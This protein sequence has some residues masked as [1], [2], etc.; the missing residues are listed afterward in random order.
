MS[1]SFLYFVIFNNCNYLK[2]GKSNNIENRMI[3]IRH[4]W[5]DI[6]Y[7]NSYCLELPTSKVFKIEKALH[8]L[9]DD[10]KIKDIS[11]DGYTEMFSLDVLETALAF[12]NMYIKQQGDLKLVKGISKNIF[13]ESSI[14]R[15]RIEKY[16][17]AKKRHRVLN[18]I[19][20]EINSYSENI[21]YLHK[22]LQFFLTHYD[23]IEYQYFENEKSIDFY[24]KIYETKKNNTYINRHYSKLMKLNSKHHYI[25]IAGHVVN[26]DPKDLFC[27]FY[28]FRD[29]FDNSLKI[30]D[31]HKMVNV[32]DFN[33]TIKKETKYSTEGIFKFSYSFSENAKNNVNISHNHQIAAITMFYN[34]I[35]KMPTKSPCL[36]NDD[37]IQIYNSYNY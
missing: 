18:S 23:C 29:N 6:D 8:N 2:I 11:G 14:K 16:T 33:R 35:L 28:A 34:N 5:G 31:T 9:L 13:L 12:I 25:K 24:I 3:K 1:K 37:L 4:L 7:E 21:N 27:V 30:F 26:A 15:K 10:F 36:H 32:F 17:G 19:K 22:A 20:K